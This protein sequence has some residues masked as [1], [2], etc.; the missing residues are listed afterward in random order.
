MAKVDTEGMNTIVTPERTPGRDRGRVI[1]RN[2]RL[3]LAPRSRAA[4]TNEWSIFSSTV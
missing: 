4:S 3:V 2:T 1:F